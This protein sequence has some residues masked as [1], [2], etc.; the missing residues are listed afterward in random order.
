LIDESE[1]LDAILE[2]G[3]EIRGESECNLPQQDVSKIQPCVGMEFATMDEA[4]NF[5]NVY[6]GLIGFS[7]R[8]DNYTRSTNGVSSYRF[9][10]SKEG[11]SK[12]Q[13]AKQ[14]ATESSINEKNTQERVMKHEAVIT[15]KFIIPLRYLV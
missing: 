6:V 2:D 4:F 8:K 1:E 14:K 12:S 7:V 5:Y 15:F 3:G 11:F 13:I 10:C 9:V